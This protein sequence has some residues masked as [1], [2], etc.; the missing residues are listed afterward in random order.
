MKWMSSVQRVF[1]RD[2]PDHGFVA[3]DVRRAWSPTRGMGY[4]GDVIVERRSA[5][6]RAAHQPPV[7]ASASR[8]TIEAV[9]QDLL[10]AAQSNTAIGAALVRQPRL[11]GERAPHLHW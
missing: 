2:L 6:R 10:P 4:H 5:D 11:H 9:L 1:Q 7:V 8:K 3:I